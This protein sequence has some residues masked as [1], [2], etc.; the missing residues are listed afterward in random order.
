VLPNV[1]PT[2]DYSLKPDKVVLCETDSMHR[3]GLGSR[4]AK[5]FKSKNIKVEIFKLGSAYDFKELQ[6][7]FSELASKLGSRSADVAVNLTGGSKLI[8]VVAQNV[9]ATKAFTCFYAVPQNNDLVEMK[10]GKAQHRQLQDKIKLNDYFNIHGYAVISKREKN[11]KLVSG[12]HAL[13]RELFADFDKYGGQ[14]SYLNKLAA[15]AEE[16]FSLKAKANIK[17]EQ[18]PIFE[19]FKK[20]GFISSYDETMVRFS[21]E[22]DRSFCKGIWLEDYL[23]QTLKSINKDDGLQDFATSIIIESASGTKHELDAAFIYKNNLYIV[24][25]NISQRQDRE[26]G[27]IFKLDDLNSFAGIY[28][29]SILVSFRGGNNFDKNRAK[30]W[31]IYQVQSTEIN[32]LEKKIRAVIG[33]SAS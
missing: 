14:V 12:S 32:E 22:D 29:F 6:K 4:L 1:L 24:D 26:P 15:G 7:K 25:A 10:G 17:K 18:V 23:H 21:S 20:H 8:S 3:R 16:Y 30:E 28:I 33:V 11:L 27:V 9:F 5:F 13:C 31:G 2:M 19:L